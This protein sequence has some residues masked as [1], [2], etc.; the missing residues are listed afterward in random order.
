MSS[1]AD[2]TERHPTYAFCGQ[3]SSESLCLVRSTQ[4]PN[5]AICS[6]CITTMERI[7]RRELGTR[8]SQPPAPSPSDTYP[9]IGV[10]RPFYHRLQR[11]IPILRTHQ[12]GAYELR[13]V[14]LEVYSGSLL[15]VLWAQA[16]PHDPQEPPEAVVQPLAWVTLTLADDVGTA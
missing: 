7:V 1:A 4:R 16:V 6:D 14:L 15:L 3:A 12:H 2:S 10:P 13:V 8:L 5:V 9:L 11:V